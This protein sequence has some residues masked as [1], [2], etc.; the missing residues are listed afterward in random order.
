M[1][2]KSGIGFSV[3]SLILLLAL[4]GCAG[5]QSAEHRYLMKGQI[6]EVN[7]DTAY[8]CVGSADGAKIGQ[9]LTV[10]RFVKIGHPGPKSGNRYKREDTGKVRI[11]EIID[12]HMADAKI[13]SGEAREGYMVELK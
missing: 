11:T 10:Y 2:R 4:S 7:G 3:L 12:E 9:E 8:L 13:T 5:L 1:N 6:L